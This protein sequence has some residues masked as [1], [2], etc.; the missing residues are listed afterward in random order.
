MKIK[1][2]QAEKNLKGKKILLR[3]DYNVTLGK[4]NTLG[5][6]DDARIRM[7][8]PTI[9]F[10]LKKK[11]IPII[12]A[13]RGRPEGKVVE[14]LRLNPLADLGH[15][16][17][18]KKWKPELALHSWPELAMRHRKCTLSQITARRLCSD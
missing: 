9:K 3:V 4:N 17:L 7:S 12:L 5:E 2:I 16:S 8:L 13:H 15:S 1:S 18:S 6:E 11:S 10:L 14:T